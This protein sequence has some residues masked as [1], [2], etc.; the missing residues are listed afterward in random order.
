MTNAI[1]K[2]TGLGPSVTFLENTVNATP[3]LIDSNV[4]FTD[5]DNNFTNGT[6]TVN[7]LLAEDTVSIKNIGG[8]SGQIGFSGGDVSYEGTVIGTVTGGTAG[9]DL[10]VTF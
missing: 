8:G 4:T 5:P 1:P 2:L 7:G 3:Q 10:T 6:L 9:A